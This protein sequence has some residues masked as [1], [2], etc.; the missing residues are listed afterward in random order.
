L[1]WSE[2]RVK[3]GSSQAYGLA[4]LCVAIAAFVRALLGLVDDNILTF[5]TF[6]PAVM[7]AALLGGI[8]VG[9]L[10]TALG[11]IVGWWAFMP[12]R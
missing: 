3:P 2:L 10:A 4:V 12:P 5:A 9:I 6:Y 11:G 8:Q 1:I 7:V